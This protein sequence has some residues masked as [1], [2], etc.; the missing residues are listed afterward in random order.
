MPPGLGFYNELFESVEES[1]NPFLT[2]KEWLNKIYPLLNVSKKIDLDNLYSASGKDTVQSDSYQPL[3][4]IQ[5]QGDLLYLPAGWSHMT[6]NIEYKPH[7]DSN[8]TD[9]NVFFT[10]GI[11]GQAVWLADDRIKYCKDIL[12]LNLDSYDCLKG[13]AIGLLSKSGEVDHGD[14][15]ETMLLEAAEYA[16]Y[17]FLFNVWST[18]ITNCA[19]VFLI[20]ALSQ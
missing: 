16:R 18:H 4:C 5:R 3:E 15:R 7:R 17:L 20:T 8:I 10:I 6:E 13:M 2:T 19:S 1:R 14:H 11:G 9:T 12:K